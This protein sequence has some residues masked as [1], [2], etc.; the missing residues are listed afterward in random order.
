[1]DSS[2]PVQALEAEYGAVATEGLVAEGWVSLRERWLA[3]DAEPLGA[4][5]GDLWQRSRDG[6]RL[7]S[8]TKQRLE[9]LRERNN[10]PRLREIVLG[11]F[12]RRLS[13]AVWIF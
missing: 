9:W 13:R 7:P 12:I 5:V 4:V 2:D 8:T 1:L 10:T 6:Y 3:H 11:R